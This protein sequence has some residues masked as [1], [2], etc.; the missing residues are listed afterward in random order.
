MLEHFRHLY[1]DE[2]PRNLLQL[3]PQLPAFRLHTTQ[4][5]LEE[6]S[7]QGSGLQLW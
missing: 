5:N 6:A 7:L 4:P 3:S 1:Q 2:T